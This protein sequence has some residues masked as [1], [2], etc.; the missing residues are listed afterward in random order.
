[1]L[2]KFFL[3]LRVKNYRDRN[4]VTKRKQFKILGYVCI[5]NKNL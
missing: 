4:Y 2:I 5:Y 3:E 1:M